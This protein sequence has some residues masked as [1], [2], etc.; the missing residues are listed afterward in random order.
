MKQ[1][2]GIIDKQTLNDIG[3]ELWKSRK[4]KRLY[5]YISNGK[6]NG[7]SRKSN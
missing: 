2:N 4:E 5:I 3:Y 7:N 1:K 6:E